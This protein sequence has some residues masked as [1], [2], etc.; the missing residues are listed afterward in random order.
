MDSMRG[1][2]AGLPVG[3][4]LSVQGT[5][6]ARAKDLPPPPSHPP[7]PPAANNSTSPM[8]AASNQNNLAAA[9]SAASTTTAKMPSPF[10]TAV[11][12]VKQTKMPNTITTP[13]E[14]QT[15]RGMI[16]ASNQ[17]IFKDGEA[18]VNEGFGW[19][20]GVASREA[21]DTQH[22]DLCTAISNSTI[23]PTDY[24]NMKAAANIRLDESTTELKELTTALEKSPKDKTLEMKRDMCI[25]NIDQAK[26]ELSALKESRMN[27]IGAFKEHYKGSLFNKLKF[28][29]FIHTTKAKRESIEKQ[30]MADQKDIA[31][32][33]AAGKAADKAKADKLAAQ[34]RKY[35]AQ[36]ANY[37]RKQNEPEE[38]QTSGV[39]GAVAFGLSWLPI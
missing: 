17:A 21:F 37:E 27:N 39:L 12:D 36:M 18:R 30:K 34:E 11:R 38:K 6:L 28:A 29:K 31:A 7:L 23:A 33:I 9:K 2:F 8:R 20:R 4:N 32:S 1:S 16:S 10:D 13:K 26:A 35:Q 14:M 25:R 24:S 19:D 3:G 22:T 5:A 15:A